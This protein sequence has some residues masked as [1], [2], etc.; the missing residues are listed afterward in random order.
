MLSITT[1]PSSNA[2]SWGEVNPTHAYYNGSRTSQDIEDPSWS[3]SI[4][5]RRQRRHLQ[6]WKRIG[7][8]FIMLYLYLL[9]TLFHE[10]AKL[11]P[12]LDAI[13]RAGILTDEAI[14]CGTLSKSNERRKEVEETGKSRGSWRDK[15]KAKIGARFMATAPPK[16]EFVNQYPKC[17]K[18]Y[19]YH[20]EDG[21]DLMLLVDEDTRFMKRCGYFFLNESLLGFSVIQSQTILVH[22]AVQ[23]S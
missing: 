18:C 5:T 1:N 17:T 20:P 14:S 7:C 23:M 10:L 2:F 16:N 9:G 11:V 22:L 3:T 4:K 21:E 8:H 15:K 12:H 6:H 13:L 19:T